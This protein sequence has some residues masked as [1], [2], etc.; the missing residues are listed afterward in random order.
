MRDATLPVATTIRSAQS[1]D[2]TP[3]AELARRTFVAA[4]GHTFTP[5]DLA[6]H[7]EANMSDACVRGWLDEDTVLLA[8]AGGRLVGFAHAGPAYPG[9][10]DG[11]AG[12]ADAALWRLY[13]T[14]EFQGSGIGERLLQAALAAPGLASAPNVYLDVWEENLGAQ[15]L[16]ARHGFR[17]AGR[18]LVETKSGVGAGYDLI[19]VRAGAGRGS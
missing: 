3:L 6:A 11:L 19:M 12:P 17:L 14:A 4:F 10:F 2:L 5:D 9:A 8:M 1:D 7:L 13:V 18:Y 15:R 16:Y